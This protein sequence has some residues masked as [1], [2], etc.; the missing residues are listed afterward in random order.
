MTDTATPVPDEGVDA[1]RVPREPTEAMIGAAKERMAH[2][3]QPIFIRD[4]WIAMYDAA[5]AGRG[6]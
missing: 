5:D 3:N 1:K 6:T 2:W 4:V